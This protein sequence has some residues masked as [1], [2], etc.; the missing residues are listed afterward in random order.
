MPTWIS[1]QIARPHLT[2][3]VLDGM[4]LTFGPLDFDEKYKINVSSLQTVSC[5]R[6]VNHSIDLLPFS[7]ALKELGSVLSAKCLG[8]WSRPANTSGG[9]NLMLTLAVQAAGDIRRKAMPAQLV[10]ETVTLKVEDGTQMAAYIARPKDTKRL[11]GII[12]LQEAFGVNSHIRD[13]T[14]RLAREGYVA[15]A[16]ELFHRTAPGFQGDYKDFQSVMPHVRAVTVQTAEADLRSTLEWLRA[17]RFAQSEQVYSVGFCM[18]GRISFL[19]NAVLPLRA[20]ASFYGA[21][22]APDLLDRASALHGPMLLI[23][24]GQDKHIGPEQRAAV[25]EALGKSGKTYV[26]AEFS[27]ADH[28]FFCDERASFQPRAARQAWAL[29][30]EFLRSY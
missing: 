29:L 2:R 6:Q 10:Q 7:D 17:A 22:I 5:T 26:N 1:V 11:P 27:D 28:G 4:A 19:A 16:P 25:A 9:I 12:V 30:L 20:A 14:E 23:W 18:G 24:G 15:V 8:S 13:V 3:L 21:G